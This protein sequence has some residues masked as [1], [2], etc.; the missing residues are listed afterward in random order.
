MKKLVKL[1]VVLM[2]VSNMQASD[3][4]DVLK[5]FENAPSWVLTPII[6]KGKYYVVGSAKDD[7]YGYTK[8]YEEA[9][10][11]GWV[12]LSRIN[13]YTCESSMASEIIDGNK[14]KFK[15]KKVLET[16][17]IKPSY[18]IEKSWTSQD[19]ELFVLLSM[20]KSSRSELS[21]NPRT[22][23][24]Q[25]YR[26]DNGVKL[27]SSF[28]YQYSYGKKTYKQSN[29]EH[30]NNEEVAKIYN[31]LPKWIHNPNSISD[32]ASVG[33]S[34]IKSFNSFY[35]V[36]ESALIDARAYIMKQLAI[37]DKIF[38]NANIN[39]LNSYVMKQYLSKDGN[40]YV[41]IGIDKD[42]IKLMKNSIEVRKKIKETMDKLRIE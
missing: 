30:L 41:L 42:S 21:L 7:G 6:S 19:N 11:N 26:D 3:K 15:S 22:H 12:E 16:D 38:N 25:Q 13:S 31:N 14:G 9:I 36:K 17:L 40:F 23:K 2:L 28:E 29:Y 10:Y 37:Y 1:I 34:N 24:I 35:L 4:F 39:I 32:F 33:V 8:Q 27:N 20:D 5:K 18:K